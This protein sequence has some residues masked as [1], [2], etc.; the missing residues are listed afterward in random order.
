[1]DQQL[2]GVADVTFDSPAPPAPTTAAGLAVVGEEDEPQT[3]DSMSDLLN[4]LDLSRSSA[5]DAVIPLSDT[6]LILPASL[7][8]S[9]R[10]SRSKSLGSALASSPARL[11]AAAL[12][13]ANRPEEA[14]AGP[15]R[16]AEGYRNLLAASTASYRD[17]RDSP[18]RPRMVSIQAEQFGGVGGLSGQ[19]R[20]QGEEVDVDQS[21][22]VGSPAAGL[23]STPETSG[24]L[25]L[26]DR[27]PSTELDQTEM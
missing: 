5:R 11:T 3:D 22:I 12:A 17:H 1:M 24:S 27:W 23:E 7:T 20:V 10:H 9:T 25:D 13:A 15:A 26:M 19:A 14:S 16:K 8:G 21:K 6:T 4:S 2:S 18:A